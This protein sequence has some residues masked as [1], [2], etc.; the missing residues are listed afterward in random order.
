MVDVTG[1][2]KKIGILKDTGTKTPSVSPGVANAPSVRAGV[3]APKSMARDVPKAGMPGAKKGF[4]INIYMKAVGMFFS[5]FYGKKVPYF[6]K[7]IGP[8]LKGFP[9]W[10]GKLPQDE[11]ISYGAIA[12]GHVMV[13]VGIVLFIVI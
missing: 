7:N 5:D 12:L 1:F 8:V 2:L 13:I 11:Q 9:R 3:T 10:W 6:F 4:N